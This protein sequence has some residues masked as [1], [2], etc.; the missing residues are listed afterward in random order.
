MSHV[1]QEPTPDLHPDT[2]AVLGAL[3]LAQAQDCFCRK[4]IADKMKPA[5][6]AKL[7]SQCAD[8]Y[9]DALKLLQLE[10]MRYLFPKVITFLAYCQYSKEN[11]LVNFS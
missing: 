10:S 3:M 1:Q 11:T 2:C 5:V 4:A 8:Y 7:C 9:A 6:V